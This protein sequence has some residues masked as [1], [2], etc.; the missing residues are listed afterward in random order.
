MRYELE[1]TLA[2]QMNA[3]SCIKSWSKHSTSL[4]GKQFP[5]ILQNKLHQEKLLLDHHCYSPWHGELSTLPAC[6]LTIMDRWRIMFKKKISFL[7]CFGIWRKR[8]VQNHGAKL[9]ESSFW[10]LIWEPSKA[11]AKNG[12][13]LRQIRSERHPLS[14]FR[15]QVLFIKHY[16]LCSLKLMW[17]Q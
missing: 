11:R 5:S 3:S 17:I 16:S 6:W 1:L 15:R 13:Y 10:F 2:H 12:H 4:P 8:S 14:H 7:I 9:W